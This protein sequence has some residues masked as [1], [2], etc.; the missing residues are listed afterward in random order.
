M[1]PPKLKPAIVLPLPPVL[2]DTAASLQSIQLDV[3]ALYDESAPGLLRY[4]RSFGL[5]EQAGED[6]VQDAFVALFR[7]LCLGRP[8]QS[9]TGW[10]FRVTRNLALKRRRSTAALQSDLVAGFLLER[11]TDPAESPEERMAFDQRSRRLQAVVRAL[12]PGDRQCL[13]LRAEGLS[14]REIAQALGMS[15]GSVSKSLTRAFSRLANADRG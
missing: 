12:K 2:P 1:R 13:Y 14:Y 10:L 15:L 7:H 8:R 9:L 3:L 4:A 11:I 6:V 5:D